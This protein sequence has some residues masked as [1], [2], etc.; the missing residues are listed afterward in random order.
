MMYMIPSIVRDVSAMLVASTTYM[1][2][3]KSV[4]QLD[5][6][7]EYLHLINIYIVESYR[8][9]LQC[10]CILHVRDAAYSGNT[11]SGNLVKSC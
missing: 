9:T 8:C 6:L 3:Y 1:Y 5:W 10:M 2:M 7:Y 4:V 11:C